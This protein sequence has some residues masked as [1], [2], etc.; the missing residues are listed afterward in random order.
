METTQPSLIPSHTVEDDDS[1]V[2][3]SKDV[4]NVDR[5]AI[6]YLL[7]Y[8]TMVRQQE[9][10]HMASLAHIRPLLD[11]FSEDETFASPE[12]I[13][14]DLKQEISYQ[15]LKQALKEV[16]TS[17]TSRYIQTDRQLMMVLK[18]L[19][20]KAPD[21]D[22]ENLTWAEF[23]QCY[24]T[25]ISGMQT[26][27]YVDSPGHRSRIKDRTLSMISLFEPP[28][29]K[30]LG[31]EGVPMDIDIP[32]ASFER[33]IMH[34]KP[35]KGQIQIKKRS[36]FVLVI[37]LIAGAVIITA[38]VM[39]WQ[40]EQNVEN[41][42]LT[43]QRP[44]IFFQ[45]SA[46]PHALKD[47]KLSQ[48]SRSSLPSKHI[49]PSTP[50]KPPTIE[51]PATTKPY[52]VAIQKNPPANK[53]VVPQ[54]L[55]TPVFTTPSSRTVP[56]PDPSNQGVVKKVQQNTAMTFAAIGSVAGSIIVPTIMKSL[57][58]L[59]G[60]PFVVAVPLAGVVAALAGLFYY[61]DI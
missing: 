2:S 57:P 28:A 7:R 1:V 27:Q 32:D 41:L 17:T 37:M 24:K 43:R 35:P 15:Q 34:G 23:L 61:V 29:T 46:D 45:P 42:S 59:L 58:S 6:A 18:T 52:P 26:L 5:K 31:N 49:K 13:D 54:P 51:T 48:P 4:R 60:A 30:L 16:E 12:S 33:T 38:T 19:T 3:T 22:C 40:Q 47:S 9:A 55:P 53:R 20:Q 8:E 50:S 39:R 25:V 21:P 10:E 11:V 56:V 36:F 44:S 14:A